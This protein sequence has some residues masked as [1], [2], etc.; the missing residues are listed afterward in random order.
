MDLKSFIDLTRID[1]G[2]VLSLSLLI[3]Q[4]ILLGHIPNFTISEIIALL[5]PVLVQVGAFS[6]NDYIDFHVDK[7]NGRFDRPL[8]KGTIKRDHALYISLISFALSIIL[9]LLLNIQS[10][11]IV[12][13][14]VALSIAYDYWA[15][16]VLFIGNVIIAISMGIPFV[17]A[18][19]TLD[20]PIGW[21][22]IILFF[23]AF[24]I[25]LAREIIKDVE[26]MPG[27]LEIGAKTFPIVFG[28]KSAS[29][30][31]SFLLLLFMIVALLPFIFYFKIT[32][33]SGVFLI[34]AYGFIAYSLGITI[35]SLNEVTA[36][37]V[38]RL[39]YVGM[40][41]GLFSLL[42]VSLGV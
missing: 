10:F 25:G 21:L 13:L 1:H 9:S 37:V 34:I 22:S 7:I 3:G 39:L 6:L 28:K 27:E 31:A 26:D 24:L 19:T 32:F 17:F 4:I 36:G 14:F 11:V 16:N 40:V 33:V 15:K 23:M 29:L 8:V 38:K 5:I 18:S 12:I 42:L 2:L 41:S 20:I 35:F 30:V